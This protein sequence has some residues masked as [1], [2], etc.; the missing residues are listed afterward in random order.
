M[1]IAR[2]AMREISERLRPESMYQD[3]VLPA[4]LR[5][6]MEKASELSEATPR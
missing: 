1:G 4:E 5:I 3:A 6:L 2:I